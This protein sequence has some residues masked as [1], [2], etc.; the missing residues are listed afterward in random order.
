MGT[1]DKEGK[2]F[3]EA[4][5]GDGTFREEQYLHG[6]PLI[7]CVCSLLLCLFLFA[8]DQT[9][10]ATAVTTIGNEF[11]AI[12]QI[13]WLTTAFLL[14]VVVFC[15]FWG[16]I[17]IIFGRKHTMLVGVALFEIGSVVCAV[18]KDM[19]TLIGGR[20]LAGIGGSAIQSL[21]FMI[22]NEVTPIDKR[23]F[24]F[25]ASGASFSIASVLGPLIGGVFVLKVSWRWCFY[26][27]LPI[28][29][30]AVA[31]LVFI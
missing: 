13:G 10:V 26:I 23:G 5:A 17:S 27:N 21:T 30:I 18:A 19:N 22:N 20:V 4:D 9:I 15:L 7:L 3:S 31:F 2:M 24:I 8:L 1:K 28:G 16:R 6:F 14:P 29:A 11:D 25:A 12:D